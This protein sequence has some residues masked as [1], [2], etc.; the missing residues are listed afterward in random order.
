MTKI[1]KE[2][3]NDLIYVSNNLNSLS[4]PK[5][6]QFLRESLTRDNLKEFVKQTKEKSNGKRN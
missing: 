1:T 5:L 2:L 4:N 3:K 6:G